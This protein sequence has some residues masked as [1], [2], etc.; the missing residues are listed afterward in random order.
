MKQLADAAETKQIAARLIQDFGASQQLLYELSRFYAEA[1]QTS[2]GVLGGRG[3]HDRVDRP[4]RFHRRLNALIPASRNKELQRLRGD[5]INDFTGR[6]ADQSDYARRDASRSNGRAL[7]PRLHHR[8][9]ESTQRS[10]NQT[11]N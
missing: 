10:R 9:R 11:R 4:W 8:S 6:R 5:L 3:R 7:K 2:A 1:E